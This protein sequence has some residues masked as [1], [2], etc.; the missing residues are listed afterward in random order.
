MQPLV[1]SRRFEPRLLVALFLVASASWCFF[2]LAEKVVNGETGAFDRAILLALRNPFDPAD[3][4]GPKWLEEAAR[5]ITSLGGP[6]VLCLLVLAV[7]AFFRLAER[8]GAALFVLAAN[9]GG[10]LMAQLLKALFNRPRPDVV[11]DAYVFSTS[12][13]SGHAMMSAAVY[14]TLGA[15]IAHAVSGLRLRVYVMGVALLL[16]GIVGITRVYLG[17]HWPSDVIAGWAAGAAWAAACW[18]VAQGLRID[19]EAGQ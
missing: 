17:V 15:L 5:D 6:G 10:A 2:E 18:G 12:F 9:G 11:P 19:Q 3:A 13:P 8:R 16:A 14:L 7:A 4:L 1:T